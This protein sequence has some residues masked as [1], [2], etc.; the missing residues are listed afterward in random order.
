MAVR[1]TIVTIEKYMCVLKDF[2]VTLNGQ[3]PWLGSK[4]MIP[5]SHNFM[6]QPYFFQ[7][8]HPLIVN[9]VVWYLK[10]YDI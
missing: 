5:F 8:S 7:L 3:N 2:I 4:I 1:W 6:I 10:G 9:V